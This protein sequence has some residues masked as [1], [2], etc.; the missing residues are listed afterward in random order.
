MVGANANADTVPAANDTPA[1]RAVPA[2]AVVRMAA[3][4]SKVMNINYNGV[5][6]PIAAVIVMPAYTIQYGPVVNGITVERARQRDGS[7]KWSIR[8]GSNCLDKEGDWVIEPLPSNRDDK[9]SSMHRWDT[10]DAAMDA[11]IDARN[12]VTP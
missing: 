2:V 5:D 4:R 6:Y 8:S 11:A 3:D 1:D 9:W 12:A 7:V 10:F